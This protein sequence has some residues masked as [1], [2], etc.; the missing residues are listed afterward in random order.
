MD[1]PEQRLARVASG[2][3]GLVTRRQAHL[4]GVTEDELRRRVE[5]GALEHAGPKTFRLFG[6]QRTPRHELLALI[7]DAGPNAHATGRSSA[8][9]HEFDGFDLRPPFD[10][11][12][13][14]GRGIRRA[15]HRIHTTLHLDPID[16]TRLG[17]I[18]TLTAERTLIELARREAPARLAASLDSGL[19]D[20]RL[21][22]DRLH[23]RI[24]ALRSQ[25]KHG[26]PK[27]LDVI[28]GGEITR[29][30]HS[31]LER[32]FLEL[33]ARVG[34]PRPLTQQVLARSGDRIVRVDF[35]F[36]GTPIVVETL[37]YRYHAT[38]EQLA[39]DAARLNALLDQGMR[40]YQFTYDH[41]TG[42]P[43]RVVAQLRAALAVAA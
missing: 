18:P 33:A 40:P 30:G 14:R 26:I 28:E 15:G 5:S 6:A 13:Q 29:G 42:E 3:L 23:Q 8:A 39:R 41:V 31:W 19:R 34:L 7:L 32:R 20:R 17:G 21:T 2:Q 1:T 16:R 43:D 22:E 11:I 25:G 12:T 38:R 4:A 10:V 27:L 36:P 9:L 37:G 24:V 35:R